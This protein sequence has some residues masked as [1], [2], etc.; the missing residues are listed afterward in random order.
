MKIKVAGRKRCRRRRNETKKTFLK[1]KVAD[2]GVDNCWREKLK[3]GKNGMESSTDQSKVMDIGNGKA[4]IYISKARL[5][6][7]SF[8]Y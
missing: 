5:E 3:S 4:D 6:G 1:I 8:I 2:R 7:E